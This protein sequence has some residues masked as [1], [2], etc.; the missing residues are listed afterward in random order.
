MKNVIIYHGNQ[1]LDIKCPESENVETVYVMDPIRTNILVIGARVFF[2]P[3]SREISIT[4]FDES[5]RHIYEK[6]E[7]ATFTY[8]LTETNETE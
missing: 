6:S 2:H 5:T 7:E 3:F 8:F 4:L 1:R